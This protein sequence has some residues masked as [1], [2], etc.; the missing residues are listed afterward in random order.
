MSFNY[1]ISTTPFNY[2]GK[3][4]QTSLDA[5]LITKLITYPLFNTRLE[6]FVQASGESRLVCM[7]TIIK[8]QGLRTLWKGS[9]LELV[10]YIPEVTFMY[11]S[12]ELFRVLLNRNIHYETT[13]MKNAFINFSSTFLGG[14]IVHLIIHPL[15]SIDLN[16]IAERK[17]KTKHKFPLH[18]GIFAA[19]PSTVV[20]RGLTF[21]LFDSIKP[22]YTKKYT[23]LDNFI[24][25]VSL[26]YLVCLISMKVSYPFD[27]VR[28]SLLTSSNEKISFNLWLTELK[29]YYQYNP[30]KISHTVRIPYVGALLFGIL[31]ISKRYEI[32][33][34]E[35][36]ERSAFHSDDKP[37]AKVF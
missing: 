3:S 15:H 30:F 1:S 13:T 25:D 2:Y 19:M 28:S 24:C 29:K 34:E 9:F 35:V 16:K 21:G 6:K 5:G 22:I 10:R 8:E 20:Y 27:M 12:K 37:V 4:L 23:Y 32:K 11:S 26:G 33:N 17:A 7:R 36:S 14:S 18:R 31:G